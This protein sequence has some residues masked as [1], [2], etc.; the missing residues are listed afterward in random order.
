[1]DNFLGYHSEWNLGSPGGWDYQRMTLELGKWSWE[2]IQELIGID[3]LLDFE[4]TILNPRDGFIDLMLRVHHKNYGGKKPF[5]VITAESGTLEIVMEN[6]HTVGYLNNMPGVTAALAA[7]EQIE[8]IGDAVTLN[9]KE[10]TVLFMDFNNDVLLKLKK[11]HNID[12]LITA[13][14]KGIVINPRGTDPINSK[15]V[16]E[17]V[18]KDLRGF[19]SE[20]T[21]YRTPWTR[22]FRER[23]TTGPSGEHIPDLVEWVRK[24][25]EHI[26]LKPEKAH[27]GEGVFV[28]CIRKDKD[29]DIQEALE[30]NDYIVQ[31]V[32]PLDLWAEEFPWLDHENKEVILKKWQTDFRCMMTEKG[33][34]GFLGRFGGIPTNVGRGGGTHSIAILHSHISI[35]EAVD[36]IN[37]AIVSLGYDTLKEIQDEVDHKAAQIGLIYTKGPIKTLLRPRI[38]TLEQ[39]QALNQYVRY[40]WQDLIKLERFWRDGSLDSFIQMTEEE[41]ELVLIQPWKG[42]PGL[43]AS[44]GLFSFGAHVGEPSLETLTYQG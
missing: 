32:I 21:V 12:P 33:L 27:S 18:H 23:S 44:D 39:L 36:R 7:P 37:D 11:E 28:G 9:G 20:D 43:F 19:M 5:V 34:I 2:R 16:F 42:G 22:L 10:I 40:I 30:R 1:M 26:V 41:K 35:K 25:W 14:K 38:I 24:N 13:A 17:A 15:G 8:L 4:N 6:R 31:E 29:S 3:I